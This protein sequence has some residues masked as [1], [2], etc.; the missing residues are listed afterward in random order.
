MRAPERAS[1]AAPGRVLAAIIAARSPTA[2]TSSRAAGSSGSISRAAAPSSWRAR[3][4][5][6]RPRTAGAAACS[7][8]PSA[9]ARARAPAARRAARA[10]R[11]RGRRSSCS[12]PAAD[13]DARAVSRTRSSRELAAAARLTFAVG[14]SRV[15]TDP[16]DLHRAGNEALLAANVAEGDR[17]T[18]A[19]V[20]V[21]AFEETG[22]YRL[23]LP[24]MSEDPGGAP[25]LLRGDG[26]A[27]GRLR[28]AVRDRARPDPRDV[29]GGRRQRGGHRAAALHPPPHGPLPARAGARALRPRRRLERRPRE[30]RPRAEGDARARDRRA[31]GPATEA[32]AGAGRVRREQKDR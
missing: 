25:A 26:R 14:H 22:A 21:L 15:A 12:C 27:A 30:A 6:R 9:R 11:E 20:A 8:P 2:T 3:T 18:T 29:P 23:L 5:T 4:T 31:A 28:R 16:V 32:G 17:P 19:P 10:P 13:E 1:E 24:A 7:R